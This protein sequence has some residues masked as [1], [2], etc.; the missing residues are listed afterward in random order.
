MV[1]V[2][3]AIRL[4]ALSMFLFFLFL[5]MFNEVIISFLKYMNMETH[6]IIPMTEEVRLYFSYVFFGDVSC[7]CSKKLDE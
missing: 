1:C 2:T 4:L 6:I 3:I 7:D 5:D